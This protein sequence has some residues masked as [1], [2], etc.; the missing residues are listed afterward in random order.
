MLHTTMSPMYTR[1]TLSATGLALANH[2]FFNRHE[3]DKKSLYRTI[4][5]LT[6]EPL[7]LY[8][9]N[10]PFLSSPSDIRLILW[11]YI[12]FFS[13]L[14]ASIV[15][16][17]LSPFH[18]L[19]D[20][21]GPALAKVSKL[22]GV[23]IWL[24]GQRHIRY[25]EMHEEYGPIIRIAPN[26]ISVID[27]DAM[28]AVL[29][30][31]GCIKGQ[32][33]STRRDDRTEGSLLALTGEARVK[34]RR[35]WAR[36]M[37]ADAIRDYEPVVRQQANR[38]FERL[39]ERTYKVV[40]LGEWLNYFS[41]DFIVEVAFGSGSY[42]LNEGD[43]TDL[44][45]AMDKFAYGIEFLS[46][47]PWL[48]NLFRDLPIPKPALRIRNLGLELATKRI[49]DGPR[50][51]DLWYHLT[52]EEGLEKVKPSGGAVASD[53]VLAVMA[54]ADTTSA[55]LRNF[56]Y[57][58]VANPKCY[59]RLQREIDSLY[60]PEADAMDSSKYN[61]LTYLD[62]CINECLRMFP[63]L[64]TG[65]LR[66][67]PKGSGGKLIGSYFIPEGTQVHVPHHAV[68]RN[69]ENYRHP[70]DFLPSRWLETESSQTPNINAFLPFSFGPENCIGKHLARRVMTMVICLLMQ[71]LEFRFADDF[72]WESWP[73]KMK[74]YFVCSREPLHMFITPRM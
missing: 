45:G 62:A 50:R 24:K 10:Y 1:L 71:N 52:D 37:S 22:Y 64:P 6:A 47:V 44:C 40:E 42:M 39:Y 53:G 73:R 46:H 60:P 69:P 35:V 20:V 41:F 59:K 21:P 32:A 7:I 38:L 15:L 13:V 43:K 16:Y 74:D 34:R 63:P 19:A 61:D 56:F 25:K 8:A 68:H 67:V 4:A 58:I 57:L 2:L 26:E 51:K 5:L 14:S 70:D 28:K 72:D 55:A 66:E 12:N 54:G 18:P 27:L 9:F 33:Y 48:L 29:G 65:G 36:G 23:W 3:A 17:R 49:Q 11:A 30:P 31:G